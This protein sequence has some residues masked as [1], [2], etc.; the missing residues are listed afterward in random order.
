MKRYL[1]QAEADRCEKA[2]EPVCKCRCGGAKHGANR[3]I[4]AGGDF[5]LLPDDDP[6]YR[7]SMTRT[8]VKKCLNAAELHVIIEAQ[9]D[10]PED[11]WIEHPWKWRSDA[12]QIIREA[13]SKLSTAAAPKKEPN[14]AKP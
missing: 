3:P 13:K 5:S 8:Q 4:V 9:P 1:S 14:D 10:L 2:K 12:C 11:S 6:H 7:P